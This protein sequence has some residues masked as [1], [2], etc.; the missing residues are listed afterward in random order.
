M[1]NGYGD[2]SRYGRP[3]PDTTPDTM[4]EGDLREPAV[5][6]LVALASSRSPVDRQ[7][8]GVALASFLETET[9]QAVLHDLVLDPDDEVARTVSRALASRADPAGWVVLV[10]AL[11]TADERQ[12]GS[13]RDGVDEGIGSDADRLPA[14]RTAL[15]LQEHPELAISDGA[16]HLLAIL[17]APTARPADARCPR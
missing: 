16:A 1:P 2:S 5:S 3:M 13:I 15:R 8:A 12:R 17:G 7:D 9:A 11:A 6:A 14:A 4:P 10:L